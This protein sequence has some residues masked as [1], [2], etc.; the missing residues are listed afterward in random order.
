MF[1]IQSWVIVGSNAVPLPG[2]VGVADYL[3]LDGYG[4]LLS[5]PVNMEL[6]SRSISF[7][8]CVLTCAIVLL[9]SFIRNRHQGSETG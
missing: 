8:I 1:A 7:Y 3:F 6:L 9:I 2:A 5:D 4:A